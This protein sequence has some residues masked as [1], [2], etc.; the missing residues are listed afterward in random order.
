MAEIQWTYEA[1]IFLCSRK[2]PAISVYIAEKIPGF[3]TGF[4]SYG[5]LYEKKWN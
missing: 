1:A 4:C 2:M 3:L 5:K